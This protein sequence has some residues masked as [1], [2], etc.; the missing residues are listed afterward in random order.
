MKF[1][2]GSWT[3][4]VARTLVLSSAIG[5]AVFVGVRL[6]TASP[7]EPVRKALTVSGVLNGGT[8]SSSATFRFYR[9]MGDAT[10]LCAPQVMIRDGMER[11]AMTGAFSVEVPLDQSGTGRTCPD[12]LFHDPSAYV[13]VLIGTT[14]VVTRRPINP[15][16]YAVYAQQYGTPDCPVGYERTSER[17]WVVCSRRVDA[18]RMID[19][20]PAVDEVVRVGEGAGAFWVDRYEASLWTSAGAPP[21]G[22][23]QLTDLSMFTAAFPINGDWRRD[24][25]QRSPAIAYSVVNVV[26]I[27]SVTWFQ[28]IEACR[29]AGKVLPNGEQWLQAAQGT[30]DDGSSAEPQPNCRTAGGV[31]R[32]TGQGATRCRSAWGAQDMIGNLWEWTSDWLAATGSGAADLANRDVFGPEFGS[33]GVSNVTSGAN[34]LPGVAPGVSLP[35]A[36]V[37]GGGAW[38]DMRA[39]R[40]AVGASYAPNYRGTDTGFRCVVPR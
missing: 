7:G 2:Q 32:L 15:V 27:G 20:S 16:P 39:G 1:E 11:D 26:P 25:T 13:E 29:A 14:V 38:E 19:G 4:F 36:L 21:G 28:A 9:L 3:R 10:P 33:D 22:V 5:V 31:H 8:A 30:P 40:Y 18:V 6:A 37:R 34:V 23:R 17:P 24:P 35:S 12:A